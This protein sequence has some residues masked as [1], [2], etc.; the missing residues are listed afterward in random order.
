MKNHRDLNEVNCNE[1]IVLNDTIKA[2]EAPNKSGVLLVVLIFLKDPHI[3]RHE[4]AQ[5]LSLCDI[6]WEDSTCLYDNIRARFHDHYVSQT[7]QQGCIA[8]QHP[9]THHSVTIQ[10]QNDVQQ[11]YW[12]HLELLI[13]SLVEFRT[14]K[15]IEWNLIVLC[16]MYIDE[17]AETPPC[18]NTFDRM[19]SSPINAL[20]Y[21]YTKRY[22]AAFMD[23]HTCYEQCKYI[24]K[25]YTVEKNLFVSLLLEHFH[26][27]LQAINDAKIPFHRQTAHAICVSLFHHLIQTSIATQKAESNTF[28][29]FYYL[30]K[31]LGD[32]PLNV[33]T[34]NLGCY[35]LNQVCSR[36]RLKRGPYMKMKNRINIWWHTGKR[37]WYWF[38]Q[39]LHQWIPFP[40][41]VHH[42]FTT[43]N[44]AYVT[45][46]KYVDAIHLTFKIVSINHTRNTDEGVILISLLSQPSPN[47][48][49][50]QLPTLFAL[51]KRVFVSHYLTNTCVDLTQYEH[52]IADLIGDYWI[53]SLSEMQVSPSQITMANVSQIPKNPLAILCYLYGVLY[54]RS[55][56]IVAVCMAIDSYTQ[57]SALN[58]N[59]RFS[60]PSQI[61]YVVHQLMARESVRTKLFFAALLDQYYRD[62]ECLKHIPCEQWSTNQICLTLFRDITRDC[63]YDIRHFEFIVLLLQ[64]MKQC[65]ITMNNFGRI[66]GKHRK[67]TTDSGSAVIEIICQF[68]NVNYARYA[69][70]NWIVS[71]WYRKWYNK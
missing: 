31:F 4:Y 39:T 15:C 66:F 69:K 23:R 14:F 13:S 1:L 40:K 58:A 68:S 47:I 11:Q 62:S 8:Y 46:Q 2:Q 53:G 18:A 65:K 52:C 9:R 12:S 56:G 37:W 59:D 71:K 36:Y 54:S 26:K 67:F 60:C 41:E 7:M 10:R 61:L 25:N 55:N 51:Q 6:S 17:L 57:R 70:M 50:T 22:C 64:Y 44:K 48:T 43:F 30:V 24:Y 21:L 16:R 29:F 63:A 35:I 42:V 19:I 5:L 3:T 38:N 34:Q 45:G 20:I 32:N 27:D 49:L 33:Y 28:K